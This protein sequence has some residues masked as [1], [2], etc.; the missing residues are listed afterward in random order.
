MKIEASVFCL[1]I[2][3]VSGEVRNCLQN[4]CK[5]YGKA[6]TCSRIGC[7]RAGLTTEC[8][9]HIVSNTQPIEPGPHCT[10][11]NKVPGF[12]EFCQEIVYNASLVP[13]PPSDINEFS[14]IESTP[15]SSCT[16]TKIPVEES[17]LFNDGSCYGT[18]ILVSVAIGCYLVGIF[19]TWIIVC[20]C[21]LLRCCRKPRKDEV[22]TVP[23]DTRRIPYIRDR[24]IGST[25]SAQLLPNMSM[26]TL[27]SHITNDTHTNNGTLP[28]GMDPNGANSESN[29]RIALW[30]SGSR[31]QY[32][33]LQWTENGRLTYPHARP[34]LVQWPENVYAPASESSSRDY[35]SILGGSENHYVPASESSSDYSG[36]Q[37]H[38]VTMIRDGEIYQASSESSG[39]DYTSLKGHRF[40]SNRVND[41]V[42][43]PSSETSYKDYATLGN[44][45]EN[46]NV[47]AEQASDNTK[48][49]T[50]SNVSAQALNS[51]NGN[52]TATFN[53]SG[54]DL[55]TPLRSKSYRNKEL[56]DINE[57]EVVGDEGFVSVNSVDTIADLCG[58][59]RESVDISTPPPHEYFKLDPM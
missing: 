50:E 53:V 58:Q 19:T 1:L 47:K 59:K 49:R 38:K 45:D 20:C 22:I 33:N 30:A 25:S 15:S 31:Q 9:M 4:H 24:E 32:P 44:E 16:T 27:N 48:E 11:I 35:Q 5:F 13:A 41:S 10:P 43:Y 39:N 37:T 17:K 57:Y 18:T 46:A 28:N 51:K 42:Y 7:I 21:R 55:P 26:E 6:T 54:L 12:L 2:V 52:K 23:S 14:T 29:S 40:G 56:Q 8:L 3:L 34:S 36:I